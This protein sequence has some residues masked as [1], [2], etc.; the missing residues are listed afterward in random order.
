VGCSGLQWV[1]V[2]CCGFQWVPVGCSGLY[3]VMENESEATNS[4]VMFSRVAVRGSV[5]QCVAVCGSFLF[6]V[7]VWFSMLQ[8]VAVCCRVLLCVAAFAV[9]CSVLLFPLL[10]HSVLFWVC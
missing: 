2:G 10:L 1:A 9:C 7:S 5:L 3:W 4:R 6:L 8:C